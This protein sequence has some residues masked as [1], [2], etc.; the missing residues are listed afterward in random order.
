MAQRSIYELLNGPN[1]AGNPDLAQGVANPDAVVARQRFV[2]YFTGKTWNSNIWA[3]A[4][5][6]SAGWSVTGDGINGVVHSG[7]NKYASLH[8]NSKKQFDPKSAVFIAT[9][10][11]VDA[12]HSSHWYRCGLAGTAYNNQ[13]SLFSVHGQTTC[14]EFYNGVS[15]A[16]SSTGVLRDELWHAVKIENHA[17]D[18][19]LSIDGVLRTTDTTSL[20]TTKQQPWFQVWRGYDTNPKPYGY[21]RYVECY[22]T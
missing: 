21:I 14:F 13:A 7:S 22:N 5:L 10:K 1:S 12:D 4:N 16:S 9:V 15:T 6:G 19:A 18:S 3:E 8:L 11:A 20:T 2:H 17:A